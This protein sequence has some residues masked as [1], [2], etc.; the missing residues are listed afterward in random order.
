MGGFTSLRQSDFLLHKTEPCN[1]HYDDDGGEMIT[2]I[3]I[4]VFFMTM[5][6]KM[7]PSPIYTIRDT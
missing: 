7:N 5:V 2:L 1:D 6:M 3:I 4:M